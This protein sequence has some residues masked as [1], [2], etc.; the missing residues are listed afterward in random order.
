MG[1]RPRFMLPGVPQ[2]VIHRGNNREP[3]FFS[4]QDYQTYLTI[5]SEVSTKYGCK[6]HAYVLMTNHIHLLLTPHDPDSSN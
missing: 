3:C 2:H 5:L 4:T 1:R 6:V